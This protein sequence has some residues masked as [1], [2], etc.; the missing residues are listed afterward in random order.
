MTGMMVAQGAGASAGGKS[1]VAGEHYRG[2]RNGIMQPSIGSR[3]IENWYS[4]RGHF[5]PD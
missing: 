1:K 3:G 4:E 5:N 2:Q